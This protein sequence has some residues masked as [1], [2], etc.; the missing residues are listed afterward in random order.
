MARSI[1]SS[2]MGNPSI[3]ARD[4]VGGDCARAGIDGT[5]AMVR[6]TTSR[7][8]T[9]RNR[10]IGLFPPLLRTICWFSEIERLN[11]RRRVG[12][13]AIDKWLDSLASLPIYPL[14]YRLI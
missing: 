10:F 8:T 4:F 7:D 14:V 11:C 2:V 3:S 13:G 5:A 9:A 12:G 6:P 1:S